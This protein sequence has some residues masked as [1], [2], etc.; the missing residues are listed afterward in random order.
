MGGGLTYI[1]IDGHTP[2]AR[3]PELVKRFQED[4]GLTLTAAGLVIF[5]EL[6]WVPGAM[7]QAEARAHRI[8]STHSKVIV[9][10]LVVP[11]SPDERIFSCLER[12]TKDTSCVLDGTCKSLDAERHERH[13]GRRKRELPT[14]ALQDRASR[15][16]IDSQESVAAASEVQQNRSS[17]DSWIKQLG[18][19]GADP[20]GATLHDL[21]SDP[22]GET[23]RI[24]QMQPLNYTSIDPPP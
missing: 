13:A 16:R 18:S 9:E 24:P 6:Y 4:E 21:L 12:K 11:N 20:L 14:E 17:L 8:G 15:G 19:T 1:R 2:G 22:W 3:R 10:F 23:L 5:V 7:E